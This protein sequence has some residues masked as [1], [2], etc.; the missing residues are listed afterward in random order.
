MS[1]LLTNEMSAFKTGHDNMFSLTTT[2]VSY[3]NILSTART[4]AGNEGTGSDPK[5]NKRTD[6]LAGS[7]RDTGHYM[8]ADEEMEKKIRN[9]RL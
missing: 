7:G 3:A 5:G 4:G 2:E 8:P 9:I 6:T 1:C